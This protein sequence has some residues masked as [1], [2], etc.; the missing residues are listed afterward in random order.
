MRHRGFNDDAHLSQARQRATWTASP[1][2]QVADWHARLA[3]Y[4]CELTW[5][6]AFGLN[7]RLSKRQLLRVEELLGDIRTNSPRL[8]PSS[9]RCQEMRPMWSSAS[10][11]SCTPRWDSDLPPVP[12]PQL[13]RPLLL[14]GHGLWEPLHLSEVGEPL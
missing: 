13:L 12:P 9:S 2:C 6:K 1:T 11:A 14:Y 7:V 5:K 10:P 8:C 3:S 4:P